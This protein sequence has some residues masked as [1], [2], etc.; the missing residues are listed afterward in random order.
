MAKGLGQFVEAVK[1]QDLSLAMTAMAAMETAAEKGTAART[2]LEQA[3]GFS[4]SSDNEGVVTTERGAVGTRGNPVPVGQEIQVGPWKVQV[5][6]VVLDADD[7]VLN[8]NEFNETP[9]AGNQY[10]MIKIAATRT[11]E[12]AA[13]FSMDM[14]C[15]FVGS[16]GNTFDAG[17]AAIPDSISETGEACRGASVTGNI[18]F[19]VASNQVAGGTLRAEESLSFED[20]ETC[21]ALQ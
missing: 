5:V 15:V 12:R 10:V 14:Y 17:Y 4:L 18:V 3:L 16:G 11:A 2:A 21:F 9:Q 13:A 1:G 19:E 6:D 20:T 7:V 8:H